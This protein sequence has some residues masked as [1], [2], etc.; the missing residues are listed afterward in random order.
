MALAIPLLALIGLMLMQVLEETLLP[1]DARDP[2]APRERRPRPAGA[3]PR[4]RHPDHRPRRLVVRQAHPGRRVA[5][6]RA[7]GA[8]VPVRVETSR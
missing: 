7:H 5:R 4:S 2:A 8:R 1:A 6:H 3:H